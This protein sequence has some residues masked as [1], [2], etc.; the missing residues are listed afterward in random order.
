MLIIFSR[1]KRLSPLSTRMK[2]IELDGYIEIHFFFDKRKNKPQ[3]VLIGN[4]L[5]VRITASLTRLF[6]TNNENVTVFY[7]TVPLNFLREVCL[8]GKG[9]KIQR[10]KLWEKT[11]A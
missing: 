6:P 3:S 8:R 11:N 9:R 10:N 4:P 2:I 1:N 5:H 7:P